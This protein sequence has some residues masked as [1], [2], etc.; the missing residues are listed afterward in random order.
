MA[1]SK[2]INVSMLMLKFEIKCFDT[3]FYTKLYNYFRA[4]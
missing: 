3:N 4:I 1:Q 2:Y